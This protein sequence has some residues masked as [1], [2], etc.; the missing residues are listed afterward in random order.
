MTADV[1]FP[2]WAGWAN[3]PISS[4]QFAATLPEQRVK[5]H[6]PEASISAGRENENRCC[7]G[8][9]WQIGG[10]LNGS[11]NLLIGF[12]KTKVRAPGWNVERSIAMTNEGNKPPVP[13]PEDWRKLAQ[14]AS[15]ESDPNKLMEIVEHL[16]EAIDRTKPES[17]KPTPPKPDQAA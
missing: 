16:C 6:L 4:D 8:A 15:A 10:R 9:L 7:V 2:L 17:S 11:R 1:R 14:Q 12:C 5:D 13:P 3:G